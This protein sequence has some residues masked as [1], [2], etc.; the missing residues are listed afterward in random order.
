[1]YW[2]PK[3]RIGK[4][5][6]WTVILGISI[7]IIMNIISNTALCSVERCEL[8]QSWRIFTI[9]IS[10]L[11]I[12]SIIGGGISSIVALTKY[13]DKAIILFFPIVLG[14]FGVLFVLGEIFIQH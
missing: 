2:L 14:L 7:I 5:S 11:A 1:M 10:L 4:I 13:H 12:I 8:N 3:T 6:F 9:I